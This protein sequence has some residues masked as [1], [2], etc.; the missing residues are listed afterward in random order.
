MYGYFQM[1][2]QAIQRAI[3]LLAGAAMAASAAPTSYPFERYQ[4]ILDRAPFGALAAQEVVVAPTQP[5]AESFAKSLRLSTIIEVDD[6]SIKVGFV[7]TRSGRSYMMGAGESQ[8]GIEVVTANWA[9]GE[10]V[11]KQGSE[12]ALIKFGS[13]EVSAITPGQGGNIRSSAPATTAANRP[14]WEERRRARAAPP[15]P[16]EPPPEPKYTGEELTKHL[17]EYQMEVIR[18]GLPP[19]PIPLT[20]E[21]DRKLVEEGVLPPQ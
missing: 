20:P 16:P 15:P 2:M 19:L 9:D 18:Q 11:L 13:G 12:M 3:V 5:Q 21:M 4:V 6:G 8:D 1:N 7:D 14:T 17:Q 10:A